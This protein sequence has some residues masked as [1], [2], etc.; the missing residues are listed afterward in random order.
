MPRRAIPEQSDNEHVRIGIMA[1]GAVGGYF[2]GRLAAAG[3][4]VVFFA[5]GDNLAALRRSGL[6]LKSTAGDIHL[7]RVN[8]T[9]DPG[10]V[11]PVDVVIFA[12][13]LWD[14]EAAGARIKPI[15][16]PHTRVITLQN[17]IDSVER[18]QPILGDVVVGGTAKIASV[19]A[20]PGVISHTSP[21]AILRCGRQGGRPDD[22]LAFLVDTAHA[23]GLDVALTP[24]IEIELWKKFVFLVG[25][26]SVS[27]A[28]RLPA[29]AWRN[30]PETRR[31]FLRLM[32]EAVAFANAKGFA[33]DDDFAPGLVAFVDQNPPGFRASM[34]YDLDRGNRLELDWLVGKV[35]VLGR[36]LGVPVPMAE[37][38]YGL[39]FP[40]RMGSPTL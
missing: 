35:V 6:I 28:T 7:P 11:D 9:D 34:A 22:R 19:I 23:A 20:E 1:A 8:A 10:S 15:V 3:H 13:K 29:G 16:G 17:G 38:V 36:A 4:D 30:E 12:V 2:G 39:L 5:R 32:Q 26:A 14:T 37:A 21:Y 33:I 27:A 18:L 24:E 25:F 31:V 40:Y